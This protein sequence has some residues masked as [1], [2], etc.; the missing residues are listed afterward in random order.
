MGKKRL[1]LSKSKIPFSVSILLEFG[2]GEK[3][4]RLIAAF[5][6]PLVSILL[7]F[8]YGEKEVAWRLS[9][10]WRRNVSILLEFGYGEKGAKS[11]RS[12]RSVNGFN[13]SWIWIWG[14]SFPLR[15]N[16]VGMKAFQ[17]FLNLDMGKKKKYYLGQFYVLFQS[18][19]NLDMGKK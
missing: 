12:A 6:L 1:C 11:A 19:L 18:F 2:Y 10:R 15:L 9:I 13:P 3:A 8:G 5:E 16:F 14:K 17:S 4:Q 7:E